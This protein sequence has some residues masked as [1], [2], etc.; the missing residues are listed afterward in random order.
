MLIVSMTWFLRLLGDYI[1]LIIFTLANKSSN[2]FFTQS[3]HLICS[4][5]E[6]ERNAT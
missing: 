2:Y 3:W 5:H 4:V 1:I 6:Y